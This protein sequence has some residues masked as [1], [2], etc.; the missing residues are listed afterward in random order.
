MDK[1]Q[2]I[3]LTG[4]KNQDLI[5][6]GIQLKLELESPEILDFENSRYN[7]INQSEQY[8]KEKGESKTF[9]FYGKINQLIN[10]NIR[11]NIND[12]PN[13]NDLSVNNANW[14]V[15][16]LKPTN[17]HFDYQRKGNNV[18][19]SQLS[20]GKIYDFNLDNGLPILRV[21]SKQITSRYRY[22]FTSIFGH[23]LEVND[24]IKIT[25]DN[26]IIPIGNYRV[27]EVNGNTFYINYTDVNRDEVS[28]LSFSSIVN[29][30]DSL[31]VD[32]SPLFLLNTDIYF[33][34]VVN[35]V[36]CEYYVKEL[37][38]IDKFDSLHKTAFSVNTYGQTTM[39][40]SDQTKHDVS[41]LIN[42][43][44]EP[45]NEVFIGIVKKQNS[46]GSL[47][48]IESNFENLIDFTEDYNGLETIHDKVVPNVV[49]IDEFNN[50][51]DDI[52]TTNS[53]VNILNQSRSEIS[54]VTRDD[55]IDNLS[56]F[57]TSLNIGDIVKHSLCEYN[58]QELNEVEINNVKHTF[59]YKKNIKYTY[60]PFFRSELFK[61]SDF[62][63]DSDSNINVPSYAV[64]N[65]K[66]QNFRWRRLLDIGFF[67]GNNGLEYPFLNGSFYVFNDIRFYLNTLN[68][69]RYD[70][71]SGASLNNINELDL[72]NTIFN[73]ITNNNDF[74][75][76]TGNPNC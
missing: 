39:S 27:L 15:V 30:D 14:D 51:T 7:Q 31:T 2:E 56:R 49:N 58:P 57:K 10:L 33:K 6:S 52:T 9:R 45:L 55:I 17:I 47:S 61:Y 38:V 48:A 40:F 21:K 22:G 68:S 66:Y 8:Y 72:L 69:N 12:K 42:N 36:E 71:G 16:L 26:T 13:F 67:E 50:I 76:Y 46:D 4:I 70:E 28:E 75:V 1:K 62:I 11:D 65:E 41:N 54:G 20:D 25:T 24:I 3:R 64:Y 53:L 35:N 29:S 63:E 34:K 32:Y 59:R 44:N 5:K 60:N 19:K 74:T 18:I 23:N 43:R 73:N 37:E